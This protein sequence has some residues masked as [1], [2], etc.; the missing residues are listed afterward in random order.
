MTIVTT[1]AR[2]NDLI[3]TRM[4][5]ALSRVPVPSSASLTTKIRIV[6]LAALELWINRQLTYTA[7]EDA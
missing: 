1:G 3:L 6:D 5:F 2:K 7:V 4:G